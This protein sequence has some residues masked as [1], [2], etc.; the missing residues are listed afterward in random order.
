MYAEYVQS[1]KSDRPTRRQVSTK[2]AQ[3]HKN[4]QSAYKKYYKKS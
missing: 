2:V 1:K 4:I 3:Q